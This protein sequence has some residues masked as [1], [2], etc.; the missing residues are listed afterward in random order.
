MSPLLF[1]VKG[2]FE[3]LSSREQWM[4]AIAGWIAILGLGVAVFIEPQGN[5]LAQLDALIMQSEHTT[6]DLQALNRLKQEKLQ[7][8]P[9]TEL[10]AELERLNQTLSSLDSEIAR[11]VDGLVS[12]AQM[13]ALMESVLR[14]SDRLT[15]MS[16]RSL[17]PQKLIDTDDVGYYMHPVEITLQ[18]R[19]FDIV[20]YLSALEALPV[21]YYWRNVDYRVTEYPIAEVTIGVYTLGESPEF[22]GGI[23]DVTQ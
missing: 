17:L 18:G 6:Q 10:E 19:Y 1:R 9:N 23:D 16:M 20:D 3:A 7:F 21:K 13:S 8:S 11:K 12:A 4:I 15:L 5:A 22:I 2:A 14:Q